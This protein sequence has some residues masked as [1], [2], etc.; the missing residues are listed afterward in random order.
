MYMC[1]YIHTQF[2]ADHRYK[3]MHSNYKSSRRKC[4]KKLFY[5]LVGGKIP[6]I[7]KAVIIREKCPQF[8]NCS[9]KHIFIKTDWKLKDTFARLRVNKELVFQM[10]EELPRA[11][12][13]EIS[14]AFLNFNFKFILL[15]TDGGRQGCERAFGHCSEG[16]AG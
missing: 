8:E 5:D 13:T 16:D 14:E 7:Q 12:N 11:S 2:K 10:H 6:Q 15:N 3:S 4:K 9:L 1:E